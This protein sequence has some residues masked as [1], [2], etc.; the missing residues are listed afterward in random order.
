MDHP[1]RGRGFAACT[2]ALGAAALLGIGSGTAAASGTDAPG[3]NE[4]RAAA[5]KKCA[6]ISKHYTRITG[7]PNV[8]TY[9]THFVTVKNTCS[10]KRNLRIDV[11]YY[12]DTAC[13]KLKSGGKTLFTYSI[14]TSL[15]PNV[16]KPRGVKSC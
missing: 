6:Y 16:G 13:Q 8:H 12:K 5:A 14:S 15:P 4:T 7:L 10:K 3:G 9:T 11:A 1:R 2:V